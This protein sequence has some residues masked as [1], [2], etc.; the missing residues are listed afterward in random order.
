MHDANTTTATSTDAD[1]VQLTYVG[2]G[3][4]KR[5]IEGHP[6]HGHNQYAAANLYTS[7][8]FKLKREYAERES[9]S[10]RVL[11]AKHGVFDPFVWATPYDLTITDYP[12]SEEDDQFRDPPFLTLSEWR[13]DVLESI[14]N[15]L[16]YYHGNDDR[17]HVQELVM[18]AGQNYLEPLHDGLDDLADEYD[19]T[20]RYPFDGTSGIGDQMAWLKAN[21][22]ESKPVRDSYASIFY[23]ED[24]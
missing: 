19:C 4:A 2:C 12:I 8:Y 20:V 1:P 6:N 7:N 24:E 15:S 11:S 22:D 16:N 13:D 5:D 18:L 21:T 23:D 10:W 3:K 14:E 9:E 17:P